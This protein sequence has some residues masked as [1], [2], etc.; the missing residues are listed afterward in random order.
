[1]GAFSTVFLDAHATGTPAI[2]LAS[3]PGS[4]WT[5]FLSRHIN[6]ATLDLVVDESEL[7]KR[8]S[9][10]LLGS[11]PDRFGEQS[12]EVYAA[13][14][15]YLDGGAGKRAAKAI[16]ELLANHMVRRD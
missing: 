9:E 4:R 14:A 16:E 7:N 6:C 2:A 13:Q 3:I 1:M 5:H 11:T 15:G 8:L 10:A 12:R